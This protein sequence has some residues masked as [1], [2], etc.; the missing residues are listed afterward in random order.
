MINFEKTYS[1]A[2]NLSLTKM[3]L[4]KYMH[5][6]NI[7]KKRPNFKQ[8]AIDYPE[9]RSH[10]TQD[11]SGKVSIDF[12]DL[13]ALRAL[14]CTLLK[15]DFALE[16]D[17]P[18]TRMIPTVPLRLNYVL[19]VED[20]LSISGKVDNVKGIDVG[21]GAC[22][23]YS[24]MCAKK[25][26]NMLA[27]DVDDESLHWAKLNVDRNFLNGSIKLTKVSHD[28]LLKEAIE[29]DE[30]DFCMCNPPFFASSQE[31]SPQHKAR[32]IDRPRPRNAFCASNNE[33]IA[34][35]GEVAFIQKMIEESKDLGQRIRIY[36]TMVGHKANLPQLKKLLREVEVISFKQSD[37]CQGYTTRWGLA[38]TFH[39]IDLRKVPEATVATA[40]KSK[41]KIP[42]HYSIM[43]TEF[44]EAI[45][46]IKDM[47]DKLLISYNIVKDGKHS[48][49][50][51]ISA[52]SNTWSHQRRKRREKERLDSNATDVEEVQVAS[53]LIANMKVHSPKGPTKRELEEDGF[54]NCKRLKMEIGYEEPYLKGFVNLKKDTN[55]VVVEF[56]FDE[57]CA[58]W[59]GLHQ[60][61]QYVK[62]N[63]K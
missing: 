20:L 39:D 48:V 54:Y 47:F 41:E 17:I 16:V 8:L 10:V 61:L 4:N 49:R 31:L 44:S 5:P 25:G 33:V 26:W 36:T 24:L 18:L 63:L 28:A 7:Y 2:V 62:N 19:W 3:S 6:R 52:Q 32:K 1:N 9:F 22:C 15:K 59:E 29:D 51:S 55:N 40:R 23:I 13:K 37:F 21:T 45:N 34:E 53:K 38:W 42:L 30:Y 27:T 60:I 46:K 57:G 56:H 43:T 14:T 12:K 50:Y 58:G 35:G 11:V